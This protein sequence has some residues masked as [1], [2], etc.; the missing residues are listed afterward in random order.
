M[1]LVQ[2]D[3]TPVYRRHRCDRKHRTARA[4]MKCAIPRAVWIVGE[5]PYA[6]IAWCGVPTVTLHESLELAEWA[7]AMIDRYA[8]GHMC[9][10][11]HVIV[12]VK[13]EGKEW[14]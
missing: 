4:F 6:L 3:S 2:L 1:V 13:L 10:G 14:T 9:N 7:E 8:C 11:R 5:G 12:R